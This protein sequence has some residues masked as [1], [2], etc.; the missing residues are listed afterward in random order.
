MNEGLVLIKGYWKITFV[1]EG[2]SAMW[3]RI[4]FCCSECAPQTALPHPLGLVRVPEP[5]GPPTPGPGAAFRHDALLCTL[6]AGKCWWRTC[7]LEPGCLESSP[8]S[9]PY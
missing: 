4:E 6:N 3:D 8:D 1:P 5:Q 2:H 9:A 7:V